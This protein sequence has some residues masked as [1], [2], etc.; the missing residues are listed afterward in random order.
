MG[1]KRLKL[2]KGLSD[3]VPTSVNFSLLEKEM[4][5]NEIKYE[6]SDN[7]EQE[8][9]TMDKVVYE[10]MVVNILYNLDPRERLIF[11]FQILRDYGFQID[12][13]SFAKVIRLSRRQY[14]RLL[15]DVRL[16]TWLYIQGYKNKNGSSQRHKGA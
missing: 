10:E 1:L 16:K 4:E 5:E 14:M 15:D 11:V 3:F 9:K 12:H 7:G 8:Q 2:A 6:P 13:A